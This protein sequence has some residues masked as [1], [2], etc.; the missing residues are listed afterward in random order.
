MCSISRLQFLGS[1]LLKPWPT[2]WYRLVKRLVQKLAFVSRI[3]A[4][5]WLWSD[6]E[7]R[8][9][10]SLYAGIHVFSSR[11]EGIREH[12]HSWAIFVC[13]IAFPLENVLFRRTTHNWFYL[14]RSLKHWRPMLSSPV[15]TH[16]R[17]ISEIR[18]SNSHWAIGFYTLP[19]V[20]LSWLKWM[21]RSCLTKQRGGYISQNG[22]KNR[23]K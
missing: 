6:A 19:L 17:V 16:P 13:N 8:L 15:L 10:E 14:L 21:V 22:G 1:W 7:L 2:G 11:E 12:V 9:L 18:G 23:W 3:F 4:Y 5:G 20:L